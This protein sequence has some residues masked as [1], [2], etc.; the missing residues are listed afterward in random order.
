VSY[1]DLFGGWTMDRVVQRIGTKSNCTYC[2]VFRRQALE[3]GAVLAGATKIATG[4]NCDDTAET[5]LMNLL[6]SDVIRLRECTNAETK[7]ADADEE[8][9][10]GALG[11]PRVK[12]LRDLYE[13][14]IVLYAH[15][16]RLEYFTTECT[17]SKEAFRGHARG[18]L[19]ALE[20]VR[21]CTVADIVHAGSQ[22]LPPGPPPGARAPVANDDAASAVTTATTTAS[23][24]GPAQR[25]TRCGYLSSRPVCRACTLVASLHGDAAAAPR[26]NVGGAVVDVSHS[27]PTA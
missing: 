20:A 26:M 4:H 18:L 16:K 8:G 10:P 3:R 2:G 12:P 15:F 19:K 17:Y 25:C 7:E 6:R 27:A 13:K 24:R 1:N 11:M 21:P 23:V 5:V 22:L 9:G 14:E